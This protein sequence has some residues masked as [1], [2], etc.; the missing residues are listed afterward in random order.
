M[1]PF[2]AWPIC[3]CLAV[4]ICIWWF[5]GHR[6]RSRDCRC[7]SIR[8]GGCWSGSQSYRRSNLKN[9][10]KRSCCCWG[11][12]IDWSIRLVVAPNLFFILWLFRLSKFVQYK[13][14]FH[15]KLYSPSRKGLLSFLSDHLLSCCYHT[16]VEI[17][18][19]WLVYSFSLKIMSLWRRDKWIGWIFFLFWR[20][21]FGCQSVVPQSIQ[22]CKCSCFCW[23]WDR[24]WTNWC[25][26][27]I[28][29]HKRSRWIW[30]LKN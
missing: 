3:W 8:T 28:Q 10:S 25:L 29:V 22:L 30:G 20:C 24:S 7:R 12:T 26:D 4:W 6:I 1:L 17:L 19:N 16:Y 13:T 2:K 5:W 21:R 11:K 14:I 27:W 9:V 18:S 15:W 23:W